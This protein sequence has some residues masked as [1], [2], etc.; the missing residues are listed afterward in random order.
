ML[1]ADARLHRLTAVA[2][3]MSLCVAPDLQFWPSSPA[4]WWRNR[5]DFGVK[6]STSTKDVLRQYSFRRVTLPSRFTVGSSAVSFF[7]FT[8]GKQTLML[9]PHSMLWLRVLPW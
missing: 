8:D 5:R 9:P 2:N 1:H 7:G 6:P 3:T 4:A